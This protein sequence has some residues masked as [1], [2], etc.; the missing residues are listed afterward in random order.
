MIRI[1]T[2]FAFLVMLSGCKTVMMSE[3]TLVPLDADAADLGRV[4]VLS[5]LGSDVLPEGSR[6]GKRDDV[7]AATEGVLA[8][9]P[10][11]TVIDGATFDASWSEASTGELVA[12]ARADRVDTLCLVRVENLTGQLLVGFLPLPGWQVHGTVAFDLELIDVASGETLTRTTRRH[13]RRTDLG[14]RSWLVSD[15]TAAF[16]HALRAPVE[17]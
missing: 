1:V 12:T 10:G 13:A 14:L 4:V 6:D 2:I 3:N 11:T 16:E 5:H 9:L 15:F 17:G 8:A 7:A